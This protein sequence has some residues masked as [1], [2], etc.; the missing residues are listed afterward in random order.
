MFVGLPTGTVYLSIYSNQEYLYILHLFINLKP[1]ILTINKYIL[2]FPP[3][4]TLNV[5]T[6]MYVSTSSNQVAAS[7]N[8]CMDPDF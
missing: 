7:C 8:A 2:L 1:L 4:R 6:N 5:L 3:S